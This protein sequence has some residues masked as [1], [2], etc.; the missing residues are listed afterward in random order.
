[1]GAADLT[2]PSL[3]GE[4]GTQQGSTGTFLPW[5]G[6]FQPVAPP[7][8]RQNSQATAATLSCKRKCSLLLCLAVFFNKRRKRT[9][10]SISRH[11][12]FTE[13]NTVCRHPVCVV[14]RS[15]P[16]VLWVLHTQQYR[17]LHLVYLRV[18]GNMARGVQKTF[19]ILKIP[20]PSHMCSGPTVMLFAARWY[21]IGRRSSEELS[22]TEC[23]GDSLSYLTYF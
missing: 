2:S 12:V 11:A 23:M 3:W 4:D 5:R 14:A 18:W 1:M 6:E 10:R 7:A 13:F 21:Y 19:L 8:K 9:I 15:C 16:S 22:L 20:G 17:S